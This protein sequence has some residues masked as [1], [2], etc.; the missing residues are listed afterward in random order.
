MNEL[1]SIITPSYNSIKFVEASISSVLQQ[2]YSN[3]ELILVDD[4][5]T[6]E[7]K[8]LIKRIASKDHRIFSLFLEKNSGSAVARNTAIKKARGRYIAFLDSDDL[9]ER[10]KLACQIDFMKKK[11]I[12][13][14]FTSYKSISED[15]KKIYSDIRAPKE[16]DYDG[17]LKNTIIGCLTV[18]LDRSKL[19]EIKMPNLRTSQD[20][21]LWLSI[22]RN[23]IKAYGIQKSL[24]SYRNVRNSTT[25]NKIKVMQGV[26]NIY[27]NQENLSIMRSIWCFLHYAFNAIKKR[28]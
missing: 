18:V 6:D 13:F 27:R 10:D 12:A 28:I 9:W 17:L 19:N 24:A 16:I 7:S 5:S 2:T 15:G 26:W 8:D 20:L 1:V 14:S 21:A 4:A 23:G 25:S 11:D 3:W 22:M